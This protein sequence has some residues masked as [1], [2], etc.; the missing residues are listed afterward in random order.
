M[1]SLW[2]TN[3]D[4]NKIRKNGIERKGQRYDFPD[5]QVFDDL[6]VMNLPILDVFF[7]IEY[8]KNGCHHIDIVFLES[9]FLPDTLYIVCVASIFIPVFLNDDDILKV[10]LLP[11]DGIPPFNDGTTGNAHVLG[12]PAFCRLLFLVSHQKAIDSH[13]RSWVAPP[14]RSG[15]VVWPSCSHLL[16]I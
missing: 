7:R 16:N 2:Q 11:F 5:L 8:I 1:P 9:I 15:T 6:P 4:K 3:N 13:F 14:C 12:T 10:L